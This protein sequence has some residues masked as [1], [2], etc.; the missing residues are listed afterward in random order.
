MDALLGRGEFDAIAEVLDQHELETAG[1]Q[2]D[3]EEWPYALHMLGHMV[4]GELENA[5][6]VWKRAPESRR[7]NDAELKAVFGLLQSMWTRDFPVRLALWRGRDDHGRENNHLFENT[8]D[9]R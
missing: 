4:R 5:R 7:A 1:A 3:P 8:R 6:F 2:P 9:T